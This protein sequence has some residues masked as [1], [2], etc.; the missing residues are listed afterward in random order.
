MYA[1]LR[2]GG[3]QLKVSPG[4]VIRVEKPSEK[5]EK[6]EQLT[7]GDVVF[8][9]GGEGSASR[10]SKASPVKATVLGEIRTRKASSSRRSGR[11]NTGGPR[12]IVRR[13]SSFAST[14][15]KEHKGPG[16]PRVPQ[17]QGMTWPTRRVRALPR[18][19]RDSNSQRLGVKRFAGQIVTGGSILV[20][21]RGTRFFPGTTSAAARTTP[22]SPRSPVSCAITIAGATAA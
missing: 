3:K 4:D 9:G 8:A 5:V 2:A 13:W 10:S 15:S 20:R 22:S 19:G 21:Q 1:I 11:S 17:A 12:D 16:N 7:L 18:N 6:G 14:R